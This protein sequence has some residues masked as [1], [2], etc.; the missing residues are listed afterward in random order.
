MTRAARSS[1]FGRWI[2]LALALF[3]PIPPRAHAADDLYKQLGPLFVTLVHRDS[4]FTAPTQKLSRWTAPLR[5]VV[6]GRRYATWQPLIQAFL[7]EL[8]ESTG[9]PI[10]MTD[11]APLNVAVLFADGYVAD[12]ERIPVYKQLLQQALRNPDFAAQMAESDRRN[13]PCVWTIL[14]ADA[15]AL[16][17][18]I[19]M[20]SERAPQQVQRFCVFAWL[21][22]MTGVTVWNIDLRAIG[23]LMLDDHPE[24]RATLSPVGRQLLRMLYDH[25]LRDGMGVDDTLPLLRE[26]VEDLR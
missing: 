1:P 24:G 19:L 5:V 26:I 6:A 12:S 21:V 16:S 8:A 23:M 2:V 14:R 13:M 22:G 17:G 10:T 3:A 20:V 11:E 4:V 15:D 9:Q 7:A 18:A 25:R